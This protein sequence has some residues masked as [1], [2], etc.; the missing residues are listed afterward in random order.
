MTAD[1]EP[2]PLLEDDQQVAFYGNHFSGEMLEDTPLNQIE[3][4]NATEG[5][6]NSNEG[7]VWETDE[8]DK[9]R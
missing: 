6:V 1:D 3:D 8:G 5:K 2:L 9:D 4:L 7:Q